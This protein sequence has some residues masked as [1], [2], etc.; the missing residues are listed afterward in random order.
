MIS[1]KFEKR[2]SWGPKKYFLDVRKKI[3]VRS[4][5]GWPWYSKKRSP[6]G[7]KKD[8]L[9]VRKKDLHQV[10]KRTALKSEKRFEKK[11][12]LMSEKRSLWGP[13]KDRLDIPK[14]ISVR[15]E[16]D[17]CGVRKWIASM[18]VKYLTED[19]K[20]ISLTSETKSLWGPKK[21]HLDAR[22]K[23]FVR[24]EKGPPWRPKNDLCE[25]RKMIS[26]MSTKLSPFFP[27]NIPLRSEKES[28]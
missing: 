13:K 1:L 7:S 26:L 12:A 23:I 22:K 11:I 18:T 16:K 10:R 9:D 4:E 19:R 3:S 6:W 25:V 15:S 24:S 20:K 17:L 27:I 2:S 21:D 14:N 8:R 5:K 28:P